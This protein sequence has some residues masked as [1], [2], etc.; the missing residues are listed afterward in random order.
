[1]NKSIQTSL[2]HA[3]RG[4]H[5]FS[6][7]ELVVVVGVII[8]L[9]SLVLAVS[10]LLI[11]QNEGRQLEASFANL[12]T[13][14]QEYELAI[15]RKITAQDRIE[16]FGNAASG[17]YDVPYNIDFGINGLEGFYA[18]GD[19]GNDCTN[20]TSGSDG[21]GWEKN[22]VRLFQMMARTEA[23]EE[24]IAKLD[25]SLFIPVRMSNGLALPNNQS[26]ST[27]VDP[28]GSTIAVVFPGRKWRQTDPT[29]RDDDGTI[30]TKLEEKFGICRNGR[31]LFVSAGPDGDVGCIGCDTGQSRRFEATLDNVY[32]YTPEKP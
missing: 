14:V 22:I 17:R 5:G 23:A 12:D 29:E 28:W 20:C 8:T 31:I 27:L 10:T 30:R 19:P 16:T 25:P 1:M 21:H 7:I 24:I 32:S 6:L 13:A 4:R 9:I 11:Q 26:L 3:R 18:V 15:G 2:R